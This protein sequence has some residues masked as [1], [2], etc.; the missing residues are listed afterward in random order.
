MVGLYKSGQVLTEWPA[1]HHL[2]QVLFCQHVCSKQEHR[3]KLLL[4]N[5]TEKQFAFIYHILVDPGDY[6]FAFGGQG[7]F[8]V[9]TKIL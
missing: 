9:L 6:F 7:N 4:C 8:Q 1:G 2:H 5:L 3:P